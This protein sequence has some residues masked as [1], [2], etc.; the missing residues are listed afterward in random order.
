MGFCCNIFN[1][2]INARENTASDLPDLIH[3][4]WPFIGANPKSDMLIYT[5]RMLISFTSNCPSGKIH[6]N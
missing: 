1:G 2:C 4:L 3:K 6:F 5:V